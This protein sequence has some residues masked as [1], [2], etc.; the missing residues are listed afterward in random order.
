M[1]TTN[2]HE[3][4]TSGDAS[5]KKSIT[6]T[7]PATLMDEWYQTMPAAA[8][9]AMTSLQLDYRFDGDT[10]AGT[11]WVH[12]QS[13]GF[14]H[15]NHTSTAAAAAD[16]AA[17]LIGS[18][19]AATTKTTTTTTMTRAY[20][21]P[22]TGPWAVPQL[23][24][25]AKS[26][27][28]YDASG[29]Y[30]QLDSLAIPQVT[31]GFD[32]LPTSRDVISHNTPASGRRGTGSV[33]HD[34]D[35]VMMMTEWWRSIRNELIFRRFRK[36]IE[37]E[38][39]TRINRDGDDGISD[40][41]YGSAETQRNSKRRQISR[42]CQLRQRD[43]NSS[44][45]SGKTSSNSKNKKS[46]VAINHGTKSKTK[47]ST[48]EYGL[49]G[50]DDDHE[51]EIEF[52][53]LDEYLAVT[54]CSSTSPTVDACNTAAALLSL[55]QQNLFTEWRFTLGS[56]CSLLLYGGG[57]SKR[58][59]L[60][61]FAA[62]ELEKDGDVVTIN[63]YDPTVTI[64][65]ILQLLI[66]HWC[67][68]K[69]PTPS[70]PS[71]S[72]CHTSMGGGS[73]DP[74][75]DS[76]VIAKAVMTAR[77]ISKIVSR[78]TLRPLYIVLHNIDGVSLRNKTAQQALGALIDQSRTNVSGLYGIRLVTTIDHINAPVLLW[79][80]FT[81]HRFQF[82]WK[83]VPS[84]LTTRY[85]EELAYD[86]GSIK[87][88][89][90]KSTTRRR[91]STVS[92]RS[93]SSGLYGVEA[94]S[95]EESIFGVLTSLASRHTQVLQQL[96]ELQLKSIQSQQ[97]QQDEDGQHQPPTKRSKKD[98]DQEDD[99]KSWVA[100]TELLRQCRHQFIV[101]N[102]SQLRNYIGE[103]MDHSIVEKRSSSSSSSVGG[104][105]RGGSGSGSG[106]GQ[107]LVHRR[108]GFRTRYLSWI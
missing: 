14:R 40:D 54:T 92:G 77:K 82:I 2:D 15:K 11:W 86:D 30:Q 107:P 32:P 42:S 50:D 36:E 3:S 60:N 17:T 96:A 59:L 48:D 90:L 63:G 97:H 34:Y 105:G 51:D 7:S 100:Y 106:P 108:T 31:S 41:E 45:G 89:N 91:S 4:T 65:R 79:D 101:A 39:A 47:H 44:S 66:D 10:F 93:S 98:R 22:T 9:D 61:R 62:Q 95:T 16:V 78:E 70:A 29:I 24:G 33:S 38:Y 52:P 87:D 27:Y 37:K 23:Q 5:T 71:L 26:S 73:Y 20:Q 81:R 69:D 64:H 76:T 72:S 8:Q 102:D 80:T 104:G 53:T 57:G 94:E 85:V 49:N 25:I 6:T 35:A 18:T 21:L 58:S 99:N 84:A 13:L 83:E 88:L 19:S 67:D 1:T 68:V 46:K 103:L 28:F 74:N 55:Q 43:A 56:S 12:L 75:V